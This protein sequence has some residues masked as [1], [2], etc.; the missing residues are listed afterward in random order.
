M[1][2]DGQTFR[3]LS[4]H[5]GSP[6]IVINS[7]TGEIVQ[8]IDYNTWGV[9]T[10]NTNPALHPFGFAG[11]LHDRHT[12]LVRFGARD[13]DPVTGRWLGKDPI[14][15]A[16]GDTNLF[17]YVG[18]NPVN[19]ID[20]LGLWCI[21]LGSYIT[22]WEITDRSDN[23]RYKFINVVFVQGWNTGTAFWQKITRVWKTRK[24][25]KWKL[26]WECDECDEN[27][28]FKIKDEKIV[29]HSETDDEIENIQTAAYCFASSDP[30]SCSKWFTT[31][32]GTGET[33][34]G[35]FQNI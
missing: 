18:G 28:G 2:K 3:I 20:P 27:C 26:C 29:T 19:A 15:F 6:R 10:G 13:Y 33:I 8:R 23:P 21:P 14:G 25:K 4:D 22:D 31:H 24:E 30:E 32:P 1:K 34:T 9:M 16:G 7:S 5:L 11:G 12:G 17:G 35:G